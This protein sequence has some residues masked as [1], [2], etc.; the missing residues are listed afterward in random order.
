M[1][2]KKRLKLSKQNFCGNLSEI[3]RNLCLFVQ[4]YDEGENIVTLYLTKNADMKDEKGRYL[5]INKFNGS[6][7][8]AQWGYVDTEGNETREG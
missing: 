4:M 1:R 5:S 7:G 3:F 2:K 8:L 6:P